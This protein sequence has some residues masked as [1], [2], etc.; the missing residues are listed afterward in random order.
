MRT[1]G[2]QAFEQ[3]D[4]LEFKLLNLISLDARIGHRELAERL[5]TTPAIVKYRTEQLE[6]KGIIAGYRLEVSHERLGMLYFKVQLF[7]SSHQSKMLQRLFDFCRESP[8]ITLYIVQ[9]GECPVEIELE[10]ESLGQ[11]HQILESLRERF[12][13]LIQNFRSLLVHSETFR[14]L[15]N[16]LAAGLPHEARQLPKNKKS[17]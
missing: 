1:G 14:W 2:E 7:L 8:H 15:P 12:A 17:R 6:A 3:I 5:D 10:V 13:P 11:Y 16:L 4:E 9:L